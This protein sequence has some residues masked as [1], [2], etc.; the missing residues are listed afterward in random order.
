MNADLGRQMALITGATDGTG[1]LTA[2]RL[3]RRGAAVFVHGRDQ[4][5]IDAVQQIR[6]EGGDA[7]GLSA[8][9]A[10]WPG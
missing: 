8:D 3:A 10:A 1:R 2:G 9:L 6:A 5:E 7:Q 4:G